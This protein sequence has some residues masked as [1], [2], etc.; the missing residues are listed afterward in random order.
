MKNVVPFP[1]VTSLCLRIWLAHGLPGAFS[2]GNMA[3]ELWNRVNIPRPGA[4]CTVRVPFTDITGT[5]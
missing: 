2:Q 1:L 5:V 3:A 4:V